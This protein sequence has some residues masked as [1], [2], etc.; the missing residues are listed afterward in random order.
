L[1]VSLKELLIEDEVET[2][3][4]LELD[5]DELLG[6]FNG[7]GS[8]VR[9]EL[10]AG[11]ARLLMEEHVVDVLDQLDAI[12]HRVLEIE[13]PYLKEQIAVL[14]GFISQAPSGVAGSPHLVKMHRREGRLTGV[15]MRPLPPLRSDG[16]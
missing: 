2:W 13:R 4:M 16:A 7:W 6:S 12:H 15:S 11:P 3:A 8:T 14:R 10:E 9:A 1:Q 5:R